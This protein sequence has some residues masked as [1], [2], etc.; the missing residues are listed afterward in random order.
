[1]KDI[2]ECV[3]YFCVDDDLFEQLQ[4]EIAYEM[5]TQT[6]IEKHLK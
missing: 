4:D 2:R 1:M 5:L 6:L 3:E